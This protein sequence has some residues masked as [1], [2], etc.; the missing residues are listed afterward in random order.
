[1][2]RCSAMKKITVGQALRAYTVDA[3]YANGFDDVSGSI[4][5]GKSADFAILE[6]AGPV[7]GGAGRSW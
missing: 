6:A 2:N 7:R 5:V 1:M 4:A 3:A